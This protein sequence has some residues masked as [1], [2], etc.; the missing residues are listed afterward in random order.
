MERDRWIDD[1][2]RDELK[3]PPACQTVPVHVCPS[4]APEACK[5]RKAYKKEVRARVLDERGG[6]G[7]AGSPERGELSCLSPSHALNPSQVAPP[8]GLGK[9]MGM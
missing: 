3:P 8:P 9:G 7:G 1:D 5:E 2:I 6:R 4:S